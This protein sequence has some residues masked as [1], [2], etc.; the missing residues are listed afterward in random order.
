[1]RVCTGAGMCAH[2]CV[3]TCPP[4][5]TIGMF[6]YTFAS[7]SMTQNHSLNRPQ[8]YISLHKLEL[9]KEGTEKKDSDDKFSLFECYKCLSEIQ[10]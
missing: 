2:V 5:N 8:K 7:S 10:Q 9:Y 4:E 3:F 6:W 1:M